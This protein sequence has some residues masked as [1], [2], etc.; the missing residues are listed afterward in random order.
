MVDAAILVTGGV[1][2]YDARRRPAVTKIQ[3]TSRRLGSISQWHNPAARW[4]RDRALG[5]GA[6][7]SGE[8]PARAAQQEDP[9][10][11]LRL[12]SAIGR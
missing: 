9:A 4:L 11:L 5:L 2:A 12:V 10:A 1:D 7:L 6:R 3:Q 8:R